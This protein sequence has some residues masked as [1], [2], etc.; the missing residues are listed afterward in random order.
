[1]TSAAR[2]ASRLAFGKEGTKG[3]KNPNA[4]KSTT[5]EKG[6]TSDSSP[7][8]DKGSEP[9]DQTGGKRGETSKGRPQGQGSQSSDKSQP[10]GD[11][12]QAQADAKNSERSSDAASD[13]RKST[14][15]PTKPNQE[16]RNT[17][18]AN[19]EQSPS[20][21]QEPAPDQP[22]EQSPA[23]QP[24][25]AGR[26]KSPAEWLSQAP[27]AILGSLL[28][29]LRWLFYAALLIAGLVAAWI[30][31]DQIAAAWRKL[32]DELRE[33]WE[34][35]FGGQKAKAQEGVAAVAPPLPSFSAYA[36]PF[37]TGNA[38]R[39]SWPALVRYTFE[40]LEVWAREQNCPRATGQTA[41]EF[42]QALLAHDPEV[43]RQAVALAAHYSQLAYAPRGGT[44][45]PK[46]SLRELWSLLASRRVQEVV[47]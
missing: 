27:S 1:V 40:A 19:S 36:D 13:K 46:E 29:A 32:I 31:R 41:H 12:K 26:F 23:E 47:A 20:E 15:P 16:P 6:P 9:S 24:S 2:K 7:T 22:P 30:Y 21:N 14:Q 37:L 45:G 44:S 43:G 34:S 17:E 33:L 25:S 35:W 39:M 38:A 11:S 5:Q 28:S 18:T 3:D 10:S 42:A 4:A 8:S